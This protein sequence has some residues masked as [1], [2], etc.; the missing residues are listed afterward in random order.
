[1]ILRIYRARTAAADRGPLL[2]HLRDE[3]YPAN[4]GTRGLRTFQA[5]MSAGD[6]ATGELV[7]VSTWTDFG[8]MVEGIG[9]DLLRPHWL[10]AMRDRIEPIAADH[11]ELVGEELRGIVPLAGGALRVF[12]GRLNPAGEAFFDMARRAQA[13]Q[14]DSGDIIASHIGRRLDERGEDAAY[15]VVWRDADAPGAYGGSSTEPA[16]RAL[17][18]HY[19]S[20]YEFMAYDAIAR[21]AGRRGSQHALLLADDDRELVFASPAAARLLGRSAARLLGRRIEDITSPR[22]RDR[23]D[24]LWQAF[25]DRGSQTAD[26]ELARPD[27]STV[28]VHYEARAHAPWRGVH[29]SVLVPP[30]T[31]VDFDD[32]LAASG[33]LARYDLVEA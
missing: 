25:L 9:G 14:L 18:A 32:A 7:L 21:V 10:E 20:S 6:G 30:A 29:A 28:E 1:M 23:V 15:V 2:A 4:V 13:E 8:A 11:Y 16:N 12:T 19:F 5:G 26:F 22:S 24:E 27:G 31:T 3:V 17:W 33:I